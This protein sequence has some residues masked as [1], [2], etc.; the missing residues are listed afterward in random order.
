MSGI[1][2][3]WEPCAQM[4]FYQQDIAG[5][6]LWNRAYG[7]ETEEN[8]LGKD[9][10][11]GCSYEKVSESAK[12][13]T[14]VLKIEEKYAVIDALLY[15]R[16]ELMEKGQF[17]EALSDEELLFFYI[18]KFG[19]ESL[20][21]VNG[22]F[23]GAIYDA[24]NEIMTLFR[25]HMGVRPLFYFTDNHCVAFSTDIRGLAAMQRVD[26]SV[27][28][29]WLWSMIVGDATMGTENTEFAHIRCVKP[30]SYITFERKGGEVQCNSSSY[31]CLG[32]KKI[33][34][35]SEKA[36][37]EGLRE[38]IT[39]SVQRRLEAVSGLVGAELSGGL[40]SGVIDILIH[41]LGREAVYF[42]WSASPEE[43]PFAEN[44]ERLII[45][46]I[47]KQEQITCNY[48]KSFLPFDDESIM[49]KKMRQM[50][51]EP[52]LQEGIAKRYILPPY[53]NT[54]QIGEASQFISREGA[55]VVFTGHGGDEGVSHRCNIY[56][57]FYNK[58]YLN[59]LKYLWSTT[60]GEN[61]RV[62][63]T[64][65][66]CHN[67]LQNTR[68]KLK[69]QYVSPYAAQELLNADFYEKYHTAKRPPLSFEYDTIEYIKKG[70]SRNRLDVVAL[71]GAYSGV[72]YLVPYLDYRVIDYA[73]SIPRHMYIKNKKNRYIFREAF[74]DLMPQSLYN[75]ERKE[76][77]SWKNAVKN[78]KS[79]EEYIKNKKD[80][81][82]M[83]DRSYWNQYLNFELLD[84][85]VEQKENASE[86]INDKGMSWCISNCIKFQN[87][88]E[89]SKKIDQSKG[90]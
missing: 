58:E 87:L 74:K 32:S 37:I 62:Y 36:Y 90:L 77:N 55:K 30:A 47:C 73:V 86:K 72:R 54:L 38:L 9:F 67:N 50:G 39:D 63:R 83:L 64:L 41:R 34:L 14:P 3:Y 68:K 80:M 52:D 26:V 70:G 84:W 17:T 57:M 45:E 6:G 25:D 5:L 51:I 24:H 7:N 8:Y 23:S 11:V 16:E 48:G 71:L 18:E 28:E 60:K 21:D 15:N 1:Y 65:I 13:S 29:K 81:V 88:I 66:R 20:K 35:G 78:P 22:D 19:M 40:D 53:I 27:D 49:T 85:W 56:E 43:I 82:Q 10:C 33:R 42:S 59:Y 4:S 12:R 69:R 44:D 61:R 2:G 89:R 75:L 76:D 79:P 46:D 31:W